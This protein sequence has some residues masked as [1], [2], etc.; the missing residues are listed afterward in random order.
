MKFE[1]LL[2]KTLN[3]VATDYDKLTF[4][5]SDNSVYEL[6]GSEKD[7]GSQCRLED[8]TEGY[9][10][11]LSDTLIV[12]AYMSQGE[13]GEVE[14]YD[15]KE[16]S[17]WT[18]YRIITTKGTVV[19]RWCHYCESPYYSSEVYFNQINPPK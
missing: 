17:W 16:D 10:D 2:G 19:I 15:D 9:E 11:V 5:C 18:F 14:E 8:I 1:S 7:W 3:R 12:E 6:V 4:Y 13:I